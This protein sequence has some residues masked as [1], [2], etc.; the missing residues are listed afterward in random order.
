MIKLAFWSLLSY[1]LIAFPAVHFIFRDHPWVF[2]YGYPGFMAGALLILVGTRKISLRELGLGKPA[3]AK[4]YM[5]GG[6]LA[7]LTVGALPFLDGLIV[8]TGLDQS[9]LYTGAGA[10]AEGDSGMS[11]SGLAAT[12]LLIPILKQAFLT[13]LIGQALL[14]K[15]HPAG[16]VYC[17]GLIFTV[18]EFKFSLGL[19][20][21]GAASLLLFKKTN[22]LVAPVILHI[23]V[24]LAS[25]LLTAHYPRL[26]TLLG[27]LF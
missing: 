27:F 6:A 4:S 20:F 22:G 14:K 21:L 5:I 9:A 7:A 24:S 12:L 16:A 25:V 11:V 13:G 10:R 18:V 15:M 17:T 2:D 19:F 23:G 1:F 3:D 8:W 26:V